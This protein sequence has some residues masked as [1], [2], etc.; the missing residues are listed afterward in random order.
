MSSLNKLIEMNHEVGKTS[1][2]KLTKVADYY[3]WKERFENFAKF[4]D[5]RMWICISE[6][7]I[8]LIHIFNDRTRVTSYPA[9]NENDK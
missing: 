1:P 3:R 5:V 7:Y 4:H 6:G 2:P 8:P 9:M